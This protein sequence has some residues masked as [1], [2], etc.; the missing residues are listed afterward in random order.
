[1]PQRLAELF[2]YVRGPDSDLLF[3]CTWCDEEESSQL[4]MTYSNM[5]LPMAIKAPAMMHSNVDFLFGFPPTALR[6]A[7]IRC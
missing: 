3:L 6:K 2:S 7:A 1:M 5:P 4:Y